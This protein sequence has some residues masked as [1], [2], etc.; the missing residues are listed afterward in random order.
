MEMRDEFTDF[1]LSNVSVLPRPRQRRSYFFVLPM[2]LVGG[3]MGILAGYGALSLMGVKGIGPSQDSSNPV[4]PT[5]SDQ[6]AVPLVRQKPKQVV[7]RELPTSVPP[8]ATNTITIA[9]IDRAPSQRV[10][11]PEPTPEEKPGPN[12]TIRLNLEKP[13]QRDAIT[14]K[15]KIQVVQ[16]EGCNYKLNP[17]AGKLP[18]EVTLE[19]PRPV[20]LNVAIDK[21]MLTIE[22]TV[23]N[24]AGK[25]V[26]FTTK[27]LDLL[28]RRIMK[29]GTSAANQ[30]AS[31]KAEQAKLKANLDAHVPMAYLEYKA[32]NARVKQLDTIIPQAEQAIVPLETEAKA[33]QRLAEF[34]HQLDRKCTITI[35]A[36]DE[37]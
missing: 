26:P 13:M 23:K 31:M 24:D 36:S 28:L 5:V 9:D 19:G 14:L 35:E 11:T 33:T 3:L 22:P 32:A 29:T 17:Q 34:A 37:N 12:Q 4:E 8:V 1:D 2:L 15:G 25:S 18:V 21:G 10:A 27:N 16:V 7:R 20:I 30:L 6:R